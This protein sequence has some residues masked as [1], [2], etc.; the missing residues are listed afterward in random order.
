MTA[1]SRDL[2]IG[3]GPLATALAGATGARL[4]GPAQTSGPFLWRRASLDTGEGLLA[5]AHDAERIWLVVPDRQPIHGVLAVLRQLPATPGVMAVPP[6]VDIPET[7]QLL[8][9]GWR[10][11]RVPSV[12]GPT[13][14]L[15]AI[16]TEQI[17]LRRHLWLADPDG[18]FA[19]DAD[20]A[21]AALRAAMT[22]GPRKS[23]VASKPL[24][25]PLLAD[26][27]ARDHGCALRATTM[28]FAVAMWRIGLDAREL[29]ARMAHRLDAIPPDAPQPGAPAGATN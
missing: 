4:V 26:R 11:V 16:W 25:L 23:Q 13:E 1:G 27:I 6:T 9:P 10:V 18:L 14:P 12:V 8:R 19:T 17:R 28:P 7:V 22:D 3:S 15:V 20:V 21:V 29:R 2:V 24:R 5:G